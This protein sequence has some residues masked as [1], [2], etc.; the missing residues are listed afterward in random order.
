MEG[1]PIKDAMAIALHTTVIHFRSVFNTIIPS[2]LLRKL[3][4][5][6]VPHSCFWIKEFLSNC[7]QRLK[8]RPHLYPSLSLNT[9]SPQRCVLSL[10]LYTIYRHNCK[11]NPSNSTVKLAVDMTMSVS[12]WCSKTNLVLN[13][14]KT[15]EIIVDFQ[16]NRSD[17]QPIYINWVER[18]SDFKFLGLHLNDDLTWKT[19]TADQ[20]GIAMTSLSWKTTP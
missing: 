18:V 13:T 5:L 2:K 1:Q 16:R 15:K 12:S 6:G 8:V 19:N 3:K 17:P 10:I 7:P 14:T 20:E 4:N 11:P 9:D